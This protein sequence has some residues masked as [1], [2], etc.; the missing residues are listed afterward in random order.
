MSDRYDEACCAVCARWAGGF[1]YRPQHPRNAPI[2]WVCDDPDCL[3]IAKETYGMKQQEFERYESLAAQEG[4]VNAEAFCD[5]IGVYDFREM[6]IDQA[7]EF[8]RRLVAGY[9]SALKVKLQNEAPF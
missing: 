5:E 9:R 1:G 2:L 6:T 8:S 4:R 7:C 3:Q